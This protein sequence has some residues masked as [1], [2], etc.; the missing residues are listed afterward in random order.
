[1]NS[2]LYGNVLDVGG[3]SDV[4]YQPTGFAGS[5]DNNLVLV[6]NNLSL[7]DDSWHNS[8]APTRIGNIGVFFGF[9][10]Y[11]G[12]EGDPF[13]G[14]DSNY[15]LIET[16]GV[17]D[18]DISSYSISMAGITL[19]ASGTLFPNIPFLRNICRQSYRHPHCQTRYHLP[20]GGVVR[21]R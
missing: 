20:G 16:S 21:Y 14:G 10:N 8:G 2:I 5:T 12:P 1:M 19:I 4:Y 17:V 6:Y 7:L 18:Q 3:H 15:F 9:V 11:N 13:D